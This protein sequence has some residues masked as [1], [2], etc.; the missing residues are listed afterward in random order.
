MCFNFSSDSFLLCFIKVS[1]CD[2]I[3]IS[4]AKQTSLSSQMV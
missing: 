3:E 2:R 4:K 1:L